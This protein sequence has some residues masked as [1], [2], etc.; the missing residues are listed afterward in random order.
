MEI[1]EHV[2]AVA[3]ARELEP[4]VV[5][6]RS[7]RIDITVDAP[8]RAFPADEDFTNP[9]GSLAEIGRVD[10][11]LT[12]RGRPRTNGPRARARSYGIHYKASP[13]IWRNTAIIEQL[14]DVEEVARVLPFE[15]SDELS[16]VNIP[17]REWRNLQI[18]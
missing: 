16:A 13:Y 2:L 1:P 11:L 3:P 9:E 18:R 17:S 10:A 4:F 8:V 15:R 5:A 12:D 7:E 14:H 6:M